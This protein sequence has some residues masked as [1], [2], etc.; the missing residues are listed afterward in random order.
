M[1]F[2]LSDLPTLSEVTDRVTAIAESATGVITSENAVGALARRVLGSDVTH[3]ADSLEAQRDAD[4]ERDA[5]DVGGNSR[6]DIESSVVMD[7]FDSMTHEEMVV[8]TDQISAQSIE[9]IASAWSSVSNRLAPAIEAFRA[10]IESAIGSGWEGS[11]A[12]AA[13]AGV[14]SSSADLGVLAE[15]A[16]EV[17]R[18]LDE[19]IIGFVQT[20][21]M[22]P[23]AEGES[24][25]LASLA[26][27]L[28]PTELLIK[29][30][31][32][33]RSEQ[34]EEALAVLKT[35]Y[36]PTVRQADSGFPQLRLAVDPTTGTPADTGASGIGGFGQ[37]IVGADVFDGSGDAGGPGSEA[38]SG[39]A[40]D[41]AGAAESGAAESGATSEPEGVVAQ[42][43]GD[44]NGAGAA[45][46]A[47][48]APAAA[49]GDTR[50]VASGHASGGAG[51]G[52]SSPSSGLPAVGAGAGS[53]AG[54]G[55]SGVG[56]G[57]FGAG[58]GGTG[59][60]GVPG[61]GTG[62]PSG[63]GSSA[64]TGTAGAATGGT[65][66]G[67]AGAPGMGMAP[68]ARGA[69]RDDDIEHTTPGYLVTVD[70]GNA[71]VGDLPL[72]APPVLG[73]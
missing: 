63:V 62:V 43:Q 72:V 33:D 24:G 18:K 7:S 48:T 28:K 3:W 44:P 29:G 17:S 15:S 54:S 6:G 21:R 55:G 64:G 5:L 69:G 31:M 45:D 30:M 65:A 58:G 49:G 26:G 4:A 22:M 1:S 25:F 41:F 19:A 39:T 61:G 10:T 11:A 47:W 23:P 42:A 38:G 9:A 35:V 46:D 51:S 57:G 34:R 32:F 52:A 60:V 14:R 2:T 73:A 67:R 27:V 59:V 13:S 68:A 12:E 37:A 16:Q 36:A 50:T 56:T 66:A 40:G 70:N 71:I 8:R 20:Q 53:A